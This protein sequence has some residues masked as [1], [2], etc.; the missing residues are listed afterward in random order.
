MFVIILIYP[1]YICI[2]PCL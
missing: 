1:G 2:A